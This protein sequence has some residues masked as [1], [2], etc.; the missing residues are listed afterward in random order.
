[1]RAGYAPS[2]QP[3]PQP[4]ALEGTSSSAMAGGTTISTTWGQTWLFRTL[5]YKDSPSIWATT[6]GETFVNIM[7]AN[8][9]VLVGKDQSFCFYERADTWGPEMFCYPRL[10]VAGQGIYQGSS[11]QEHGQS[12]HFEHHG[13]HD[14]QNASPDDGQR[15]PWWHGGVINK[16][17]YEMATHPP[18]VFPA[19]TLS[20][21]FPHHSPLLLHPSSSQTQHTTFSLEG[22]LPHTS[23]CCQNYMGWG[24]G[25]DG[26]TPPLTHTQPVCAWKNF[27]FGSCCSFSFWIKKILLAKK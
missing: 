19:L 5:G 16:K 20:A 10:T 4:P 24:L 26:Q 13:H 22:P 15:C 14:C 27:L 3:P 23:Y 11:Y 25:L 9:G 18:A 8:I 17:Y 2:S 21:P 12:S 1:M 6:S 7:P